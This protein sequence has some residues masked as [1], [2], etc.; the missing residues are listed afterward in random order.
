MTV[1]LVIGL[2]ALI[3]MALRKNQHPTKRTG[4]GLVLA[5][6]KCPSC[7][8]IINDRAAYCPH[9]GQPTGSRVGMRRYQRKTMVTL[10]A[11]RGKTAALPQLNEGE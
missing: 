2:L 1:A 11:Q 5:S 10:G 9:C 3:L 4:L 8:V 6:R 7:L